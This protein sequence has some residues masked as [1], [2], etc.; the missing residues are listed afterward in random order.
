ME[1]NAGT[2]LSAFRPEAGMAAMQNGLACWSRAWTQLAE[3]MMQAGVAQ[4]ELAQSMSATD[5]GS[6]MHT[7]DPTHPR[8]AARALFNTSKAK[9]EAAV[10]SYR[11]INDTLMASLFTAADSVLEGLSAGAGAEEAVAKAS[12]AVSGGR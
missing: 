5:P 12:A 8:A 1:N 6:W 11:Q 4:M 2:A 3:G 7:A 10:R 9:Y